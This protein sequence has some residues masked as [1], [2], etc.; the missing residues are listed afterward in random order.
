MNIFNDIFYLIHEL[1]WMNI[2]QRY[3]Y[4]ALLLMY[5]CLN[6]QTPSYLSSQFNYVSS[7][8]RNATNK[9]LLLPRPNTELL[10]R[11][12]SYSGS[13]LWN[14]LLLLPRPNTELFK[15]SFSYSGSKLWNDLPR[16]IR[17]SSSLQQFKISL[18]DYILK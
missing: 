6:N 2:H 1:R 5:K 12:F 11:S 9:N 4:F 17:L 10:K 18:K 13:K 15:R 14:D 8:T 7:S 3:Q 16:E